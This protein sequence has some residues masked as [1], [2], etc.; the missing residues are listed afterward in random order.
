MNSEIKI[1]KSKILYEIM[2]DKTIILLES[3]NEVYSFDNV[4]KFIVDIILN[5]ESISISDII[6]DVVAT[7]EVS[8]DSAKKDTETFVSEFLNLFA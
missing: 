2:N 6:D 8:Q 4:S 5:S 7:Y 1:D 3:N